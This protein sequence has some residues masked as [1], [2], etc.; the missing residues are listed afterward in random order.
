MRDYAVSP[1]TAE[2]AA[3]ETKIGIR[4]R[5]SQPHDLILIRTD[6]PPDKLPYDASRAKAREDGTVGKTAELRAGAS[7]LMTVNLEPGRYLLICNVAGH[8]SLG[9]RTALT[10]K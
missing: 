3:G 9:M 10:V 8:Y 5:G 4:N 1:S 7:S 6:L 2:L